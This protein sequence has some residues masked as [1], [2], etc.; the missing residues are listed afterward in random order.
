M[1]K[2]CN[3]LTAQITRIDVL[4]EVTRVNALNEHSPLQGAHLQWFIKKRGIV[5][6]RFHYVRKVN[7]IYSVIRV[8]I[9]TGIKVS[10][11]RISGVGI[12]AIGFGFT[13]HRF[14]SCCGYFSGRGTGHHWCVIA[15]R[16]KDGVGIGIAGINL[17]TKVASF[18]HCIKDGPLQSAFLV[19]K[20]SNCFL[21]NST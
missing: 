6:I 20:F 11:T 1:T 2:N 19:N 18:C 3:E 9:G 10:G 13:V 17:I 16:T 15:I 4:A 21:N 5:T 12:I 7:W 14:G 8:A